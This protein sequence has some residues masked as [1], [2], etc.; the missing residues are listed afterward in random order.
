MSHFVPRTFLCTLLLC[1]VLNPYNSASSPICTENRINHDVL[2]SKRGA[3]LQAPYAPSQDEVYWRTQFNQQN[4]GTKCAAPR[5]SDPEYANQQNSVKGMPVQSTLVHKIQPNGLLDNSTKLQNVHLYS[6]S[7]VR[8][9]VRTNGLTGKKLQQQQLHQAPNTHPTQAPPSEGRPS[10]PPPQQQQAPP[11]EGRPSNTPNPPPQEM[12]YPPQQQAQQG[13]QPPPLTSTPRVLPSIDVSNGDGKRSR[14]PSLLNEIKETLLIRPQIIEAKL[15]NLEQ[16]LLNNKL[17][18]ESKLQ[19][20]KQVLSDR[21]LIGKKKRSVFKVLKENFLSNPSIRKLMLKELEDILLGNELNTEYILSVL[22]KNKFSKRLAYLPLLNIFGRFIISRK[23]IDESKLKELK[24]ILLSDQPITESQLHELKV[25]LVDVLHNITNA[26]KSATSQKK[27]SNYH[28]IRPVPPDVDAYYLSQRPFDS[29]INVDARYPDHHLLQNVHSNKNRNSLPRREALHIEHPL[30]VRRTNLKRRENLS[31][32]VDRWRRTKKDAHYKRNVS[33]KADLVKKNEL[34]KKKVLREADLVKE[35]DLLEKRILR[36]DHLIGTSNL[37]RGHTIFLPKYGD[38]IDE[39]SAIDRREI[40]Q[41]NELIEKIHVRK[42]I[43]ELTPKK[44]SLEKVPVEITPKDKLPPKGNSLEKV[45]PVQITPKDDKLP[46]SDP[47]VKVPVEI[48][49]K[50]D[51]LPKSDPLVKVPVE[52]TT[53]DKLRKSDPLVKVPVEITPKDDKLRKSD[54]L[55]KVPV[56]IITKDKLTKSDVANKTDKTEIEQI[57]KKKQWTIEIHM[58]GKKQKDEII[59]SKKK[60]KKTTIITTHMCERNKKNELTDDTLDSKSKE[61]DKNVEEEEKAV[62]KKKKF[63]VDVHLE[64]K[65]KKKGKPV[66]KKKK[67]MIEAIMKNVAPK[68]ELEILKELPVSHVIDVDVN[69]PLYRTKEEILFESI[70][71]NPIKEPSRKKKRARL[72]RKLAIYG[73]V[74]TLAIGA[75]IGFT[76]GYIHVAP[77]DAILDSTALGI[78]TTASLVRENVSNIAATAG[79]CATKAAGSTLSSGGSLLGILSSIVLKAA[80]CTLSTAVSTAEVVVDAS[81]EGAAVAS[82]YGTLYGVLQSLFPSLIAVSV[83]VLIFILFLYLDE[84]GKMEWFHRY[85]RKFMKNLKRKYNEF[86]MSRKGKRRRKWYRKFLSEMN[87]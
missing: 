16:A 9:D 72:L 30:V 18:T 66:I 65:R 57:T 31:L 40:L 29:A 58:S 42:D 47:L 10:T 83:A 85:R 24:G 25:L 54:P 7:S 35:N 80:E 56:E 45:I 74:P 23:L 22:N 37:K 20:V 38:S 55:V 2:N 49:P 12:E 36:K 76:I 60:K 43:K 73:L 33:Q 1:V 53:K 5:Y 4:D 32:E 75:I 77:V 59:T 11:S 3:S 70:L 44:D 71:A 17:I 27:V 86:K 26:D 84:R 68:K 8:E 19:E 6:G 62:A 69:D 51:K 63:K 48:T 87:T 41:K 67:W 21:E 28:I 61:D 13:L 81:F 46:K 50:D 52:I 82:S 15:K 78:R 39:N 64:K 79:E 34:L 14:V